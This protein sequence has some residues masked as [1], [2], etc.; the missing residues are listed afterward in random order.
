MITEVKLIGITPLEPDE[1]FLSN[2]DKFFEGSRKALII[3][4]NKSFYTSKLID[5]IAHLSKKN[6]SILLFNSRNEK[7]YDAN[8]HLTSKDL[9]FRHKSS[10]NNYLLGASCHNQEQIDKANEL[11]CNYTLISP[12]LS[13]KHG[14]K[15]LGWEKFSELAKNFNGRSYALGGVKKE[16]LKKSL[17][18]NGAGISGIS[19][20]F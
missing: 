20:F 7:N 2:L 6:K 16:D 15:K 5:E 9:M 18:F 19:S 1:R 10:N 17:I 4:L 13:D 14:N 3:R 11:G 8:I 12:V